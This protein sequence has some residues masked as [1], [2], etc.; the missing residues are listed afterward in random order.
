MSIEDVHS[1]IQDYC[2]AERAAYEAMLTEP[3]PQRYQEAKSRLQAFGARLRL[4]AN[5]D[6]FEDEPLPAP[7]EAQAQLAQQYQMRRQLRIEKYQ[8]DAKGEIY[9]VY[10]T[11]T[12]AMPSTGE[13]ALRTQIR[14]LVQMTPQGWQI[15]S[16]QHPPNIAFPYWETTGGEDITLPETPDEVVVYIEEEKKA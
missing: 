12:L 7:E 11:G 14:L 15:I 10:L 1:F 13:P 3:D 5:I 8:V 6:R 4:T 9:A 2:D 16:R